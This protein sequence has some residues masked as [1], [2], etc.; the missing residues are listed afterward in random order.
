MGTKR[1][2]ASRPAAG[3]LRTPV[4]LFFIASGATGLVLEVV[5]ARVL[6]TVFGN[7]VYASSTVLTAFMLGLALGAVMLG[8]WVDRSAKPL[9]FYGML[10][11]GVGL[12]ALLFP[13]IIL[14][15]GEFYGWFYR[16]F[17]P[18]FRLLTVIRFVISLLILLPP[19]LLMGGTLPALGRHLG[20]AHSE[21]GQEVG[22][23]YGANTA[24]AVAGCFFTGFMLLRLLGVRNSLWAA[25]ALALCIGMLAA[26]LGRRHPAP[27]GHPRSGGKG[28]QPEG[29][30]GDAVPPATFQLVLVVF[31]IT[32][33]CSLA[34]EVL[35]IRVLI[36][37]LTTSAYSFATIVTTFLSGIALG[38]FFSSRFL[39]PRLRR[40]L[41]GFG[42]LQVLVALSA[43]LSVPLL[44]YL[45]R[46]DF[47]L[48]PRF[49]WAGTQQLI[50]ARFADAFVILLLP[51]FLMGAAYPLVMT[52]CLRGGVPLGKRVGQVYAANTL[53]CV[54]GSFSAGF[55]L[56]PLLGAHRG[57]LSVVVLNLLAGLAV[58]WICSRETVGRQWGLVA[59]LVL[60]SVAALV[61]TPSNVFHDTL[62][63]YHQPSEIIFVEEHPTGTVTVHDLPNGERLVAV[64]GVDVAG[65][66]FMLRSTQ[67]LQGYIPLSL[68]PDPQRVV[69]IGFGSGETARVALEF[70]VEDYTVVDI[71]PA[72]FN[73]G[74]FFEDINHGSYRDPRIRRIIM[75]GKNFA[76]L[77]GEKF[78]IVM[79]DSIY[80]GSGGSSA[81]YARDHFLNCRD[82]LKPGGFLSCW[83]PLD[84]RPREL[85]MILRSFQD[86]F[87]HTSFWVASNCLNKHGLI[88]GTVDPLKIDLEHVR[89]VMSRPEVAADLEAVAIHN[90][91]DLLDCHVLGE[92]SIRKLVE[93]APLNTDDHPRLEFSCANKGPT[94]ASLAGVLSMLGRHHAPVVPH[95]LFPDDSSARKELERRF[96]ATVHIFQSQVAQLLGDAGG[97]Q[98]QLDLALKKNPGEVHVA[99]C[100]E[101][102]EREI[103][104]LRQALASGW[105]QKVVTLR[106]ADRLAMAGHDQE[107]ERLLEKLAARRAST[108]AT[109]L[110]RLARA[111]FRQGSTR[112]AERALRECLER[113]PETAE[114]HDLLAGILIRTRRAAA[115]LEHSREAVRLAPGDP[116]YNDHLRRIEAAV[117]EARS[118]N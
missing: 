71:C 88:L 89:S 53:G 24:G 59:P 99:S 48:L 104:D 26:L 7:T 107:A 38:S 51:T 72:V 110:T 2:A 73:A 18:D 43:L 70:G 28:P 87:P 64:D 31:A 103:D 32:G 47:H 9:F 21:P 25:A 8:R 49:A 55:L 77:S 39:V 86:A 63:A 19:T 109:V 6:G 54:A 16:S 50:L 95:V 117:A 61:F 58:V 115:A 83:V 112:G 65:K 23:L 101:E 3:R 92:D 105:A 75:D 96:H 113:W 57:I 45:E 36:F 17:E 100:N 60:V 94:E 80:P 20:T 62:N 82:R 15:C 46:I 11:I 74:P 56:L 98:F 118:R 91:Y 41:V 13:L 22:Y 30:K 90:V 29:S 42:V 84:L 106:L 108:T 4:L 52:S 27:E 1:L 40:P 35:W 14:A 44:A 69:Q 33:F 81:L 114:A 5:W 76:F 79:N 67:K 97:R 68:H 66:D 12:Y 93:T 37:V 111:R 34:L 10:E 78:D 102:L 85:K 116:R